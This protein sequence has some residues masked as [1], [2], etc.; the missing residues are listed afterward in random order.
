MVN[1]TGF[2]EVASLEKIGTFK[3]VELTFKSVRSL[4]LKLKLKSHCKD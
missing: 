3:K 1:S 4:R 2:V